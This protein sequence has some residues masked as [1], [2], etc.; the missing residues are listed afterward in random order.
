VIPKPYGFPVAHVRGQV[1]RC[2]SPPPA[3]W[4]SIEWLV[5]GG[6]QSGGIAS[7]PGCG[8]DLYNYGEYVGRLID[9]AFE[10]VWDARDPV[11]VGGEAFP[12]LAGTNTLS[13]TYIPTIWYLVG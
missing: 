10:Q 11:I 6:R 7:L 8:G 12:R 4:R 13:L 5:M 2:S 9:I 3:D 1:M